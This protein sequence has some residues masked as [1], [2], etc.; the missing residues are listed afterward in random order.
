MRSPGLGRSRSLGRCSASRQCWVVAGSH[1]DLGDAAAHLLAVGLP[2]L[3]QLV[4]VEVVE[5]DPFARCTGC[6]GTC[7]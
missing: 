3:A 4:E 7:G 1:G 5:T 6:R 2:E